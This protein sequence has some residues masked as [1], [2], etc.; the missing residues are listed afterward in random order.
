MEPW[1]PQHSSRNNRDWENSRQQTGQLRRPERYS[2]PANF[3]T[4]YQSLPYARNLEHNGHIVGN[5]SA[6]QRPLSAYSV[7]DVVNNNQGDRFHGSGDGRQPQTNYHTMYSRHEKPP[8][9]TFNNQHLYSGKNGYHSMPVYKERPYQNTMDRQAACPPGSVHSYRKTAPSSNYRTNPG[10]RNSDSLNHSSMIDNSP[11]ESNSFISEQRELLALEQEQLEN[12]Y[13]ALQGQ[14]LADF[15]Q[16]QQELIEVYNKSLETQSGADQTIRSILETSFESDSE[17]TLASSTRE[18]EHFT[19]IRTEELPQSPFGL[20]V[21]K[22]AFQNTGQKKDLRSS[23]TSAERQKQSPNRFQNKGLKSKD[24]S[25]SFQQNLSPTT[26]STLPGNTRFTKES[27]SFEN[28][29]SSPAVAGKSFN[30]EVS[31]QEFYEM[32]Y[33]RESES[34]GKGKIGSRNRKD[35][36]VGKASRNSTKSFAVVTSP[37]RIP[38][39]SFESRVSLYGF[40]KLAHWLII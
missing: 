27:S 11:S 14:L 34:V 31:A 6:R 28:Q 39:S 40:Q 38:L 37:K 35:G 24:S 7:H 19:L 29:L 15:Q 18:P 36:S 13:A 17:V 9:V 3:E 23:G 26:K 8:P 30:S 16:R 5:H 1:L 4:M 33:F 22:S 10:L 21:K 20:T 12:H 2:L 25:R 32:P